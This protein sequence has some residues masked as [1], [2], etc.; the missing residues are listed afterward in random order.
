LAA[1]AASL[2]AAAGCESGQQAASVADQL[3]Q[4]GSGTAP[5]TPMHN[6]VPSRSPIE[7]HVVTIVDE[8]YLGD[9]ARQLGVTVDS[10]L[11][12]NGLSSNQ[13]QP[14]QQLVVKTSRELVV[15]FE[16][17]GNERRERKAAAE[18]AKLEAKRK[19][20]AEA[21]AARLA[22]KRAAKLAKSRKG[23][24]EVAA[25]GKPV[26]RSIPKKAR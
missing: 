8:R 5:R 19:A 18:R 22:A 12:D 16:Q 11:V 15:A 6:V 17:A 14:G 9:V 3:L 4:A 10:L 13:L 1:L 2:W 26:E 20:E 21:K 7:Q 24:T 25:V 23:K